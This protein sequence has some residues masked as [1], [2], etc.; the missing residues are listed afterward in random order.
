MYADIP[1]SC[2]RSSQ[3]GWRGEVY[4]ELGR[5][6]CVRIDQQTNTGL[7]SSSTGT[8]NHNFRVVRRVNRMVELRC[9]A[10]NGWGKRMRYT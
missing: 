8:E 3:R 10:H 2:V 1:G 6:R 7:Y 4:S 9:K 5:G